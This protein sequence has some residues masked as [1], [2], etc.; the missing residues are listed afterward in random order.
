MKELSG[1]IRGAESFEALSDAL[2]CHEVT[3]LEPRDVVAVAR[4]L[5]K[6]NGPP[7]SARIALLGTHTLEPLSDYLK[8]RA[9]SNR[10]T[11]DC[12]VAPYGQYMQAV[13]PP[14]DD[15]A[16][17]NP[18]IVLLSAE[19]R[20]LSP[21]VT[22]DFASLSSAEAAAERQRLVQ[23]LVEWADL[24]TQRTRAVALVCNFPRPFNPSFGVADSKR[25]PSEGEFYLRLNLDLLDALRGRE[26]ISLF[27]LDA[28]VA[29]CGGDN[30]WTHRL[31]YLA[32]QPWQH[33]LSATVARELWR[34]VVAAK[35]WARKCLVL[36]LDN[37]LW[38]GVIGEDGPQGLRVGPGD[39]EGEAYE[40]FQRVVRGLKARGVVLAVA[41]KNNVEDV[42]AAFQERSDM[43][44]RKDD[45]AIMEIG[46][47]DK[48]ESIQNIAATLDIG[49][50]SLVFLDDNPA[51]RALVRG[52]LPEVLVPDLPEDPALYAQFLRL[53]P[54]FEKAR[55][56]EEDVGKTRQYKE[57]AQR[58]ALRAGTGSM[59][60]YLA[61][62]ATEVQVWRA[63]LENVARVQQLFSKTNQFNVT[64]RRYGLGEVEGFIRSDQW[65][66]CIASA[67]DRFG[68]FG[69]IGVYL[70]ELRGENVG[71]DSFLLSCR[72]LG[73]GIESA[74]MNA[75]KQDARRW[76]PNGMLTASFVP[77]RKN[78]PAK[79]FFDA[80]GFVAVETHEDGRV[81]YAAPISDLTDI[82]VPHIR[83]TCDLNA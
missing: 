81:D 47:H 24:A 32:K 25:D 70:I 65:R 79:G 30:A 61:D 80:Q 7:E 42:D 36:D 51:E 34:H 10:R 67:K 64:T 39:A 78:A 56:T 35:G 69:I 14:A 66:L 46:W 6:L 76:R 77:T 62:L 12:W 21:R 49:T 17:F 5:A 53:Q 41:S 15:L 60:R 68:E 2:R 58:A 57:Q 22:G 72:A 4:K 40:D 23:H 83:V 52:S 59:E 54:W 74:F 44:L 3:K 8:V 43:P 37:T 55:V 16:R 1:R 27:D 45:F 33:G 13:C 71:V 28:I 29:A 75:L 73:R 9:L 31:Y 18:D 82:P 11:V 63:R 20:A 50:D 19:L 48:A 38:G 26:R